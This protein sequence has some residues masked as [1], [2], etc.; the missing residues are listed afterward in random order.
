MHAGRRGD[1][2]RGEGEGR[3]GVRGEGVIGVSRGEGRRG[4][5]RREK[6]GGNTLHNFLWTLLCI[7]GM[8]AHIVF[9][10]PP[11]NPFWCP[12]WCKNANRQLVVC[13]AFM[14]FLRFFLNLMWLMSLHLFCFDFFCNMV[15]DYVCAFLEALCGPC[16]GPCWCKG[17][18]VAGIC[19]RPLSYHGSGN[20]LKLLGCY[21][22]CLFFC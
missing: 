17:A 1:E 14:V 6:G 3:W 8:Q 13:Y 2:V 11:W 12:F 5:G 9:Q 18:T 7:A 19:F 4:E 21:V 22:A 20:F 16:W 10:D 15:F